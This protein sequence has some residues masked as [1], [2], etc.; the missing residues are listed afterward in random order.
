MKNAKE[1]RLK[2]ATRQYR[3]L[4]SFALPLRWAFW[5]FVLFAKKISQLHIFCAKGEVPSSR[6]KQNKQHHFPTTIM[7][8]TMNDLNENVQFTTS[9]FDDFDGSDHVGSTTDDERTMT[10]NDDSSEEQLA[11]KETRAVFRSRV[12]VFGALFLA[13]SIV[14]V[15]VYFITKESEKEDFETTFDGAS[16]KLVESFEEIVQQKIGA[17][18][19]LSVAFT[20]YA[21]SQNDT[22]PFVTMNDFQQRAAS[23]RSLSDS[24][25]LELL[26]SCINTFRFQKSL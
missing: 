13:A 7:S 1:A 14:S 12:L 17:L 10:N 25:F 2:L 8:K 24:L 15:V 26:V 6:S 19:S 21:R 16:A 3:N 18:N 23:A 9:K 11:S 5:L 20:S 4:K 22:W